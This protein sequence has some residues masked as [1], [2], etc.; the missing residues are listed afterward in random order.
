MGKHPKKV[1]FTCVN[2]VCAYTQEVS[3]IVTSPFLRCL[4]TAQQISEV[5]SLPGLHTCNAI[6]DI[7]NDHCGIHQQPVVPVSDTASLGINIA[8]VDSSKLPTYPEKTREGVK[9]CVVDTRVSDS[10]LFSLCHRFSPAYTQLAN[11][12][13]PRNVVIVS[14][15]YGVQHAFMKGG[16]HENVFVDYCGFVELSR[17]GKS[18]DKWTIVDRGNV[19]EYF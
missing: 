7:I 15:G 2:C 6:V 4:Q 10:L 13:W 11:T 9:R 1:A 17:S 3:C 8:S 19:D 12:Y 16:G 5:L 14:H 18:S